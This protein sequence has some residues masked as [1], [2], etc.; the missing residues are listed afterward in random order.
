[1][2]QSSPDTSPPL[3]ADEHATQDADTVAKDDFG[4][5]TARAK[6]LQEP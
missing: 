4:D 6:I 1:M 3:S 2:R 5:P